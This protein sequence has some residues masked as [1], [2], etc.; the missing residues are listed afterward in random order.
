MCEKYLGI[1]LNAP[2]SFS[3]CVW[4]LKSSFITS[5]AWT[6]SR[7]SHFVFHRS[8]SHFVSNMLILIISFLIYPHIHCVI[9]I[10]TAFKFLNVRIL[11]WPIFCFLQHS[12]SNHQFVELDCKLKGTFLSH[13]ILDTSLHF[14]HHAPIYGEYHPH[15]FSYFPWYNKNQ[16]LKTTHLLD[17]MCIKSYFHVSLMHHITEF[18]LQNSFHTQPEPFG[19]HSLSPN[20]QT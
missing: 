13:E 14:I 3:K 15:Q 17:D 18:S 2:L 16:I 4:G 5:H 10:S 1:L 11:D 9:L 6:M 20:L 7:F 8:H 12:W 19:L